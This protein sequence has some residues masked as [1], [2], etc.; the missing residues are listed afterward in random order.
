LPDQTGNNGKFLTTDGT[1]AS[2]A[3]LAGGGDMLAANNLS[4]VDAATAFSNIKQAATESASGVVELA[5]SAETTAG[6]AVQASDTR[7]SDARTPTA[8][9]T[10]HENG[11]SDEISVAG[12]SGVLADPQ[13]PI[14]GSGATEAVAGNDA[15]L[16][17]ERVPTATGLTTKFGTNKASLV[18]GDKVGILDSAASDAPKHALWSLVKSTL[19][20]YFD[21]L[22]NASLSTV[23]QAEAEA[24]TATTVRNWTAERVAQAIAALAGGGGGGGQLVIPLRSEGNVFTNLPASVGFWAGSTGHQFAVKVDLTNYTQVRFIVN[25]Q[26]TAGSA[27]SKAVLRYHTSFSTTASTYSD[28]GTSAV[29]V[30]VT[31]TNT[32]LDSGWIDLASGAKADVFIIP[33]G[34]GGD[35]VTD[36]AFGA[37]SAQFK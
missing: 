3:T 33:L 29:E 1:M 4:E 27:G 13:P 7:L 30:A 10:S 32:V 19:K 24:G 23:S 16:T 28:I 9:K 37:I 35:G 5:T 6:L 8:H 12:L 22:Y 21:T 31:G 26:G 2:W 14:I 34:Y 25:K 36:P 11:G 17:D 15:R 18:D 20:T